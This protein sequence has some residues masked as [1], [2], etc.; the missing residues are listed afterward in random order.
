M[1]DYF[2]A[3]ADPN[4]GY[5]PYSGQTH[6][7]SYPP[8]TLPFSAPPGPGNPATVEQISQRIRNLHP[9]QM[10]ALA[11]Q[12]Q[13]AWAFL[14]DVRDVVFRQSTVLRDESWQSPA[15]RDTF[16][17]LGPGETLAYLDVWMEAAQKNVIALRHLVT[18]STEAR[19]QMELLLRDYE[20]ELKQ[21]R[22][23]GFL[24]NLG[25]FVS[26]GV[27]WN[28][29]A[30]EKIDEDQGLVRE[31]YRIE[32][33]RLAQH[34]GDQFFDYI[35]VVSS[36][37]GP[38]V[39]PLNAVLS[40][41]GGIPGTG[42]PGGQAGPG[43]LPSPVGNQ[44]PQGLLPGQ[45]PPAGLLPPGISL[46]LP[47]QPGVVPPGVL[48]PGVTP[49]GTLPPGAG[50][51]QP[52]GLPPG[53]VPPAVIPPGTPPPGALPPGALPP[54][55]L[56]PGAPV[57]APGT[58]PGGTT[59]I[60]PVVRPTLP[61][62]VVR[63]GGRGPVVVPPGG[64]PGRTIRR[65][66]GQTTP[67]VPPTGGRQ[68]G[69]PA[70]TVPP[71][72]VRP[73]PVGGARPTPTVVPGGARP[74]P[75]VIPPISARPGPAGRPGRTTPGGTPPGAI[76]PPAGR[77]GRTTPVPVRTTPG[78]V[79]PLPTGRPGDRR[80][81]GAGTPP[82]GRSGTGITPPGGF[83][84]TGDTPGGR[85]G[86]GVVPPQ[87]GQPG[88]MPPSSSGQPVY[89]PGTRAGVPDR[90]PGAPAGPETFSR[91]NAAPP[92]LKNPVEDRGTRPGSAA[93][94]RPQPTTQR[95]GG[96]APP[97]LNRPVS[98]AA[99]PPWRPERRERPGA[100]WSD[101]FGAEEARRPAGDAVVGAPERSRPAGGPWG[102]RSPAAARSETPGTV[103][104]ELG[105]RRGGGDPIPVREEHEPITGEQAF[106][107]RTPGGGVVTGRNS[108]P[109]E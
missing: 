73:T 34:Y 13:N 18:V 105:R 47:Q 54:G 71:G 93:E 30:L 25:A 53:T 79:P 1:P 78:V 90:V 96:T 43:P 48:P 76:P 85:S 2:G 103:A 14:A 82:A 28:A 20:Q 10:A 80:A 4:Y 77:P 58:P 66:S 45:N 68:I 22:E 29:A 75:T 17:R 19:H 86:T 65:P 21:T 70:P 7:G 59:I 95:P 74:T 87:T 15:A 9:E 99:P 60:P 94:V 100:A 49:P 23:V 104:P 57:P 108:R 41:P 46:P 98:P 55:T 31:K 63:P 32:A 107:V 84:G 109:D 40:D 61:P 38:P 89:R 64:L 33:Q 44:P 92:V 81:T 39:Q 52:G 72:G 26:E 67:I 102:L 101:L 12:W 51:P 88:V 106:G 97:V 27:S 6:Y 3:T 35:A 37:V 91:P 16:L 11:D 8:S 50:L 62:Q 42:G 24:E 69:R 83:S 5:S 36:G 56:P